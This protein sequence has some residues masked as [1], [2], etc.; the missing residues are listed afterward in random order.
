MEGEITLKECQ[1][2]LCTFKLEKSPGDDVIP[3]NSITALVSLSNAGS[4]L[5]TPTS[6]VQS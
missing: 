4:Q 3:G 1:D 5:S 2:I 6:K